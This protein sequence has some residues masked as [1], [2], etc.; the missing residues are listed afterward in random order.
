MTDSWQLWNDAFAVGDHLIVID[1]QDAVH[2]GRYIRADDNDLHLRSKTWETNIPWDSVRFA[3]HAGF[4][5]KRDPGDGRI[6]A[7]LRKPEQ[8]R[9]IRDVISA[10]ILTPRRFMR[11][12]DPFTAEA[13]QLVLANEEIIDPF[14]EEEVDC[15]ECVLMYADDGARALLWD[16][17]SVAE[18]A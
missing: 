18:A 5:V 8:A 12:G 16:L 9:V 4:P 1:D 13:S 2:F 7:R 3:A 17:A 6:Y 11:F 10:P 14:D 15:E